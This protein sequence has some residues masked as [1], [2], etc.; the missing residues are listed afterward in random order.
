MKFINNPF[1]TL[2]EI[3]KEH[4]PNAK[5]DIYI[6]QSMTDGK[7]NLGCTLF[8]EEHL[9]GDVPVVEIHFS[10]SLENA[11]EILAHELAHVIV[12]YEG[13]HGEEWERVFSHIHEE[14]QRK[15]DEQFSE[16]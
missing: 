10:L 15:L 13:D 4:Y 16:V 1:D 6:G 11:T 3:M 7:E 2:M 8:P 5:C 9:S 14:F 12:G